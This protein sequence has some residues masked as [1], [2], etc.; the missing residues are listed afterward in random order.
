L[1]KKE[2]MLGEVCSCRESENYSDIVIQY[3]DREN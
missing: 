1:D 2:G 3:R